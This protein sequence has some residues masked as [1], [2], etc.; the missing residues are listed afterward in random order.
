MSTL[1]LKIQPPALS[2]APYDT[3]ASFT[4]TVD[5]HSTVKHLKQVVLRR[6]VSSLALAFPSPLPPATDLGLI[7]DGHSLNDTDTLEN[8]FEKVDYTTS[9]PHIDLIVPS[10]ESKGFSEV[11]EPCSPAPLQFNNRCFSPAPVSNYY[12]HGSTSPSRQ[13]TTTTTSTF[14]EDSRTPTPG[15]TERCHNNMTEGSPMSSLPGEKAPY[16]VPPAY[17]SLYP[18]VLAP[19]QYQYVLVNGMPYLAPSYYMP[20]LH[21]QQFAISAHASATPP[22]G[23]GFNSPVNELHQQNQPQ[24]QR[25]AEAGAGAP[26]GNAQD[27][28]AR[29]QRRAASLWLL[30][31]LAFGV[32]LFSQNGSIERIVLLHIAALIIFLH[33]TGRLRIVRRVPRPPQEAP[34]DPAANATGAAGEQPPVPLTNRS[35]TPAQAGSTPAS[36][37][38]ARDGSNTTSSSTANQGFG[39][40]KNDGGPQAS[41][42]KHRSAKLDLTPTPSPGPETETTAPATTTFSATGNMDSQSTRTTAEQAGSATAT[43]PSAAASAV[44][45]VPEEQRGSTWRHVEH[46]ILT[47]IASLIPTPPPENEQLEANAV[48]AAERAL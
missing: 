48:P 15:T 22:S 42:E 23:P 31:K 7:F 30:L 5:R 27:Q 36:T 47:F 43:P 24:S 19:L 18:Q 39:H 40:S 41:D 38:E 45:V 3:P 11:N 4:V 35:V 21:M 33:Q 14:T 37:S 25:E 34:R 46:G 12:A 8:I 13:F 32:Y 20:L 29:G 28:A 44:V 17:L 6:L 9:L 1:T 10:S 26:E 2:Y 16:S